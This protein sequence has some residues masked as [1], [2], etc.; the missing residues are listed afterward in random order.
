MV[1]VMDINLPLVMATLYP[2]SRTCIQVLANLE[3]FNFIKFDLNHC[4]S[5]ML[6]IMVVSASKTLHPGTIAPPSG[7][8][9]SPI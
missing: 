5:T 4:C 3:V 8:T 2:L 6:A 9:E 7:R 1:S